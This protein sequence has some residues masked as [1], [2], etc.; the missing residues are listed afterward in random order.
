M[1]DYYHI[2]HDEQQI[3]KFY[4]ECMPALETG[5][6]YFLSL[7]ARNKYLTAEERKECD[8]GRTEMFEKT[9]IH[10]NGEDEFVKHIYR[11]ECNTRGFTSRTGKSIPE[12][13]LVCYVNL[14]P[15]SVARA[16]IDFQNVWNDY[17]QESLNL[18]MKGGDKDNFSKRLNKIDKNLF[19]CYQQA[20][21]RGSWVDVDIDLVEKKEDNVE[22]DKS[23]IVSALNE[24]KYDFPDYKIIS[25]RSGYHVLVSTKGLICDPDLIAKCLEEKLLSIGTPCKEA[26]VNRNRMVPVPGTYQAG[27]P[28]KMLETVR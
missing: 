23:A 25:T 1:A 9:L 21:V 2:V 6:V 16:M 28:I 19:A 15:S 5:Q 11:Y 24:Y 17:V 14:D 26:V 22:L 13:C 8:L 3:R 10:Y 7:S 27:Y 4:N 20:H 18:T 12:K